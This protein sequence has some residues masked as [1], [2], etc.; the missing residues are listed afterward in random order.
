MY[1]ESVYKVLGALLDE[2]KELIDLCKELIKRAHK[3]DSNIAENSFREQLDN[4]ENYGYLS[5]H[6][7]ERDIESDRAWKA[8]QRAAKEKSDA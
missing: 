4:F 5:I 1:K 6:E 2:R 8:R 3:E 7:M